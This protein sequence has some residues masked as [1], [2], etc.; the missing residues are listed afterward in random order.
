MNVLY[1]S[2][3]GWLAGLGFELIDCIGIQETVLSHFDPLSLVSS[4]LV[5]IV[6][7]ESTASH[8]V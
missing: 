1:T 4:L 2:Y 5:S 6:P 3:F 7:F 8:P